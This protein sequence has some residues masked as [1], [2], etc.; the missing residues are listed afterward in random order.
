[1]LY[2]SCGA[3]PETRNSSVGPPGEIISPWPPEWMKEMFYLT[4]HL[5]H[6][7]LLVKDHSDCRGNPL[8]PH[9]LFFL[10]TTKY[11]LYVS[12]YKQDNTYNSFCYTTCGALAGTR[13][14]SMGSP[15]RI[16]PTTMSECC[17]LGAMSR[18][19]TPWITRRCTTV[20]LKWIHVPTP[21]PKK[22]NNNNNNNKKLY[23][24]IF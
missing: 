10:I 1:M 20:S 15:W 13:N 24:Y 18:S 19:L 9:G 14:S 12:S 4:T 6:F 16:D 7:F 8:P 11:F 5:T 21:H 3:L 17:Y 23:I 2:P 22:L